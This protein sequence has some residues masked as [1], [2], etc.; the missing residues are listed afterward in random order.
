MWFMQNAM[1]NPNNLGAGAYHYMTITGLV[2]TG[3][4]WLKMAKAAA[5]ALTSGQGLAGQGLGDEDFY[6]AK[7]ATAR[8]YAA[9]FLPD[10]GAL[11][12][13]IEGGSANLMELPPEAFFRA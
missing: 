6:R 12:R 10:A 4:M 13:K 8:H 5:S 1:T 3:L 7:L 2:A 9:S 11:R